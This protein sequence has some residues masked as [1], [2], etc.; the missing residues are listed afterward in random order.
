[1]IRLKTLRSRI[2]FAMISLIVFSSILIGVI[3]VV[4]YDEQSRDYHRERLLRKES[5]VLTRINYELDKTSFPRETESL[6]DIFG[7]EIYRMA[8]VLKVD[9]SIYDP[10]G[11]LILSSRQGI[12]NDTVA[13]CL[14][15]QILVNLERDP[16]HRFVETKRLEE[17]T[18][19]SSYIYL[20]DQFDSETLGII[21][22]PYYE[23]K[24]FSNK[25]LREFLWRLA[26]AY[27]VLIAAAIS[28]AYVLSRYITS[29]LKT[30]SN[31][32]SRTQLYRRNQKI[33]ISGTSTEVG[34][35]VDSYNAMIDQLEESAA[36]LARSEREYA[37]REMAK[38]VAHEIKNP[39]TPMRL[40][41]QSM[42]RAMQQDPEKGLQRFSEYSESLIQQIDTLSDIAEAFSNFARLPSLK[43]EPLEVLSIIRRTLEV[44]TEPSIPLES[45]NE[46]ITLHWDRTQLIR[47]VNNLVKNAIQA[48]PAGVEPHIRVW[49]SD[50]GDEVLIRVKDNGIGIT[51][52]NLEKIFEPKFTTKT[53]GMGLGL[54]MVKSMI[55]HQG[56]RMQV[57]S[58]PGKGST[59]SVYLLKDRS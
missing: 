51:E 31:R 32:I 35:L 37:W 19:L 38:Q 33:A 14:D 6:Q 16:E 52:Q 4:Q 26:G 11:G 53:S 25:E 36:K 8:E 30:I 21:N 23:D 57:D 5:Q 42:Q 15:E 59:F 43:F 47:T 1:M 48:V 9:F 12:N 56:G 58:V 22:L 29:T 49:V 55:E 28:A 44:F 27:I 45:S 54:A 7:D 3:T 17:G 10:Q 40:N 46:T 41:V 50:L 24:S 20:N 34:T 39:L 2:F 18:F 13:R